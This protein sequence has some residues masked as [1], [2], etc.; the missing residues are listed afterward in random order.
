MGFRGSDRISLDAVRGKR[1]AKRELQKRGPL[2]FRD[3]PPLPR[4]LS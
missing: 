3:T 2:E 1:E 4:P